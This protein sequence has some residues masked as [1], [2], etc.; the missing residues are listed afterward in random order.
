MFAKHLGVGE[1]LVNEIEK[2][3][4][5]STGLYDRRFGTRD[6]LDCGFLR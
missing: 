3:V 1:S 5:I 4:S 6:G 2:G